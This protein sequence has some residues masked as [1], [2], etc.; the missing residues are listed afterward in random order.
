MDGNAEVGSKF[1]QRGIAQLKYSPP[2]DLDSG[3]PCRNDV[4]LNICA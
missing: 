4:L 1:L 3:N 2:C